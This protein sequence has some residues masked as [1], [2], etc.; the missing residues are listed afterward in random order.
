[1]ANRTVVLVARALALYLLCWMVSD[2]LSLPRQILGLYH[3]LHYNHQSVISGDE[4]L[5][6]VYVLDVGFTLVRIIGLF[7]VA[8]CLYRCGPKV[9]SFFTEAADEEKQG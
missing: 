3:Y 8:G 2:V 6:N 1:M 7:V 9:R 4:Y 5:R